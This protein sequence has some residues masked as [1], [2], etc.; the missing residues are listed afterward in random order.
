MMKFLLVLLLLLPLHSYCQ[1]E[2][3]PISIKSKITS[4]KPY[5]KRK[6][7]GVKDASGKIIIKAQYLH[8]QTLPNGLFI[9]GDTKFG[10]IDASNTWVI[11]KTHSQIEYLSP[12]LFGVYNGSA[13]GVINITGK[14]VLPFKYNDVSRVNDNF[15]LAC[16][17]A[18]S[19][20]LNTGVPRLAVYSDYFIFNASG[21]MDS[22]VYTHTIVKEGLAAYREGVTGC[23][24][25][26]LN[27][28]EGPAPVNVK[29]GYSVFIDDKGKV[30]LD[31]RKF[32]LASPFKYGFALVGIAEES[33]EQLPALFAE[34]RAPI[35]K[36]GVIDITGKQILPFEYGYVE[37][38]E[39]I[40]I[41][42]QNFK[43]GLADTRGNIIVAPV[44]D[45]IQLYG[46]GT[47]GVKLGY[48]KF[49]IDKTGKRVP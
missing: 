31:G 19:R 3:E 47:L 4:Y 15:G 30:A 2:T 6:L 43:A 25:P 18:G 12:T 38:H 28:S 33:K 29:E 41:V 8:F 48:E 24:T 27:F 45:N 14:Q 9:A 46:N 42:I 21:L 32:A 23:V 39:D 34:R 11:P 37:I 16:S 36:Y 17:F 7:W 44:Y 13:W 40:F 5:Q 26:P 20:D 35:V 1:N 22:T 49:V 10:V